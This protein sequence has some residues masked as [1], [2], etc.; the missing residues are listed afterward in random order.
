MSYDTKG[1]CCSIPA[2]EH[3]YEP[4]GTYISLGG[5]EK[6]Y[7]TGPKDT[8]KALVA[9][10]DIFGFYPQT[11]QGADILAE[12]L[13]AQVVIPDFFAPYEPIQLSKFPPKTDEQK[14]E[15]GKFFETTAAPTR[16]LPFVH[17]VAQ[18]LKDAGNKVGTYGYC[19]GGK[20]TILAGA[21]DDFIGVAALHPAMLNAED[22]TKVKVP[23][24]LFPSKDE[25]LDEY[26]KL[27]KVVNDKPFAEKNS[28]KVYTN[29]H[30]GFAA[31]R[32]DLANAANKEAYEDVYQR[33]AG[34]FS[35]LF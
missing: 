24:A 13:G 26:E 17:N 15:I 18:A 5:V 22:G 29:M 34:F 6:V 30:H 35:P 23:V 19:W 31:A 28:Y 20:I 8:G 32:G 2:V 1:A 14:Q 16:V 9:V 33:L 11:L 21:T 12:S 10:Y 3:K 4:K 27:L 7:T 25:P